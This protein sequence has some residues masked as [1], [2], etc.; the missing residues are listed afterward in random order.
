M[1]VNAASRRATDNMTQASVPFGKT[2]GE[3]RLEKTV[4][5]RKFA[6]LAGG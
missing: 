5:L 1:A 2:L 6:E 4:T 3:K